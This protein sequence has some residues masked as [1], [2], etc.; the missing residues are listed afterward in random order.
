[1][2]PSI[3]FLYNLAEAFT[4]GLIVVVDKLTSFIFTT[5]AGPMTDAKLFYPILFMLSGLILIA[6]ILILLVEGNYIV[7][8]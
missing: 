7:V 5:I 6:F 8:N 1:M 3:V 4:A 2:Y